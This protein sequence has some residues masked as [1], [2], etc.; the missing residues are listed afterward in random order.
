MKRITLLLLTLL[1]CGSLALAQWSSNGSKIY[2]NA[3]NVGIGTSNPLG[4]LHVVG[5]YDG[6]YGQMAVQGSSGQHTMAVL[7]APSSNQ[8]SQLGLTNGSNGRAWYMSARW[9]VDG[10]GKPANRLQWYYNTGSNWVAPLSI[11]ADSKVGIGT[12]NPNE[13]LHLYTNTTSRR[14]MVTF[15]TSNA[16]YGTYWKMGAEPGNG[17][18]AGQF[19]L[20]RYDNQNN[21]TI[22]M[23]VLVNGQV[24]LGTALKRENTSDPAVQVNGELCVT[25]T[26]NCPDYVFEADYERMSLEDLKVYLQE[27]K[28]LPGVKSAKEIEEQGGVHM[29]EIS[30][31]MLEKIEELTLYTIEQE[32]SLSEVRAMLQ[33]QAAEI[34]ALKS[35]H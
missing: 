12:E 13:T 8:V 27:N 24:I 26:G 14:A 15:Q 21:I 10:S 1:S 23:T 29:V 11:T 18:T 7:R 3:N 28:H 16:K 32:E 2:Y 20:Y 25:T 6:N 17:H 31:S 30:Y 9:N 22:P 33:Q 35:N 5:A 19:M 4:R 34:E